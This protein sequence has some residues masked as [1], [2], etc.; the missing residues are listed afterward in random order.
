MLRMQLIHCKSSYLQRG[1]RLIPNVAQITFSSVMESLLYHS[2]E[3]LK[4][5]LYLALLGGLA[6]VP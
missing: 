3:N 6:Q 2:S 1:A 4:G 5:S